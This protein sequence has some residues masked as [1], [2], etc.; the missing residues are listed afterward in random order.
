MYTYTVLHSEHF[1]EDPSQKIIFRD[2]LIPEDN[3]KPH[4]TTQNV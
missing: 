3:W 1:L 2:E 4:N